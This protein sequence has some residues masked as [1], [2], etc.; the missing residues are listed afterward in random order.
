MSRP[1]GT[2]RTAGRRPVR[3]WKAYVFCV[4]EQFHRMLRSRQ[5]FAKNSSQWSD[6]RAKLLDGE[7]WERV[8]PTVLVSLGLPA[9]GRSTWPRGRRGCTPPTGRSPGGC[10]P[11]P[12][13]SS[14]TTA[15]CTS[16]PGAGAGA[17][18]GLAAQ[19]SIP[20]VHAWG[21]GLVASV[22]G[23]RFVVPVPSVYARPNPKYFG[24]RGGATWLNMINDQAA[25]L[26]GKVVAGT[27]RD[28]LYVLDVL[29]DRDGGKRPEMIVTDSASYSDIVF[30]CSPWPDMRTRRSWRTCPDG[31]PSP[32]TSCA[33]RTSPA[34]AVRSRSRPT[35]RRAATTWPG[36]SSM[37]GT[38]AAPA[39][40]GRHGG[41][42]RRPR[43][44]PRR[45]CPVQHPVPGRCRHPA[46]RRRLRGARRGRVPPLAVC[47]A[48]HQHTG[49]GTPSSSPI[50]PVACNTCV[51]R[52]RSTRGK[53]QRRT[54]PTSADGSAETEPLMTLFSSAGDR[55]LIRARGG[56]SPARR[57]RSAS[58]ARGR[59][60]G[61]ASRT[62]R[63][64]A[65]P[66]R[67]PPAPGRS[68]GRSAPAGSR[69]A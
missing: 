27:P 63:P 9:D 10:R 53:A 25:G 5:I 3:I 59:T 55:S 22:D 69:P 62:V 16:P 54:R 58:P 64:P 43:L 47:A 19:A 8:K 52:L 42:D 56:T 65:A 1:Q 2:Q 67:R 20:L 38:A 18:T 33:W 40:P 14:A 11:T 13:S 49:P 4:L 39:L 29:Y 66:A 24:R 32:C 45:P 31:S 44:G 36:R 34:T 21:G 60:A 50:C 26:G 48:S 15:G 23:M 51:I 46:T 6:P 61:R 12:R 37:V 57:P 35:C 28:S 41:P 68:A 30:A 17:R 7:A